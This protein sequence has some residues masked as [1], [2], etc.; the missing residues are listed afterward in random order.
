[1]NGAS[2]MSA[3]QSSCLSTC[4][5]SSS[6][7]EAVLVQSSYQTYIHMQRIRPNRWGPSYRHVLVLTRRTGSVPADRPVP[8]RKNSLSGHVSHE[9]SAGCS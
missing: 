8:A 6:F 7:I 1:M 5:Q 3:L 2:F 4:Q 9:A